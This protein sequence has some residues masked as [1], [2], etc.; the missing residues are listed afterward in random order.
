MKRP[1][2][3]ITTAKAPTFAAAVKRPANPARVDAMP[4]RSNGRRTETCYKRSMGRTWVTRGSL[5]RAFGPVA[6]LAFG[7][8]ESAAS[9]VPQAAARTQAAPTFASDSSEL[10]DFPDATES[11]LGVGDVPAA[12][13]PFFGQCRRG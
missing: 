9:H 5:A 12:L 4:C 7:C 8:A 2:P 1:A 6:C 11:P 13:V 10:F 3:T